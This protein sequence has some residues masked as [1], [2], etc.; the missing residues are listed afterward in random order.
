MAEMASQVYLELRETTESMAIL[1]NREPP[2]SMGNPERMEPTESQESMESPEWQEKK[3]KPVLKV[4]KLEFQIDSYLY[5][6]TNRSRWPAGGVYS[7]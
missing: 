6:R 7:R 2:V 4:V 3:G 1:G 5:F